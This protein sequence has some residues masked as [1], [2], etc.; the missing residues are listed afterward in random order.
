[1]TELCYMLYAFLFLYILTAYRPYILFL[2]HLNFLLL[3]QI[4]KEHYK[5]KIE[6]KFRSNDSK[7]MWDR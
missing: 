6:S 5:D 3:V 1:M 2:H 4:C 7:D